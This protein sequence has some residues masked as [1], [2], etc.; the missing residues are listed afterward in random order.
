MVAS[1]ARESVAFGQRLVPMAQAIE[2]T[3]VLLE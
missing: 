1:A 2:R 3:V